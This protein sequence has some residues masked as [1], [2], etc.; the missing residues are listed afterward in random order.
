MNHVSYLIRLHKQKNW[1]NFFKHLGKAAKN[2][3]W[4]QILNNA[5]R[6]LE[7]AADIGTAAASKDPKF[8]TA[9]T[10]DFIKNVHQ[11]NGLYLGK[12]H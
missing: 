1:A 2:K 10:P 4:K 11:G 3:C 12:I 9:T 6:A 5:G 8:I 7:I